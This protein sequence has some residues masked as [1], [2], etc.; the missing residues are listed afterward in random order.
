[1]YQQQ[2][3]LFHERLLFLVGIFFFGYLGRVVTPVTGSN[4]RKEI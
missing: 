1:M 3:A 2:Q 4:L